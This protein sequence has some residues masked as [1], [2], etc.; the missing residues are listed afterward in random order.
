M[1]ELKI[2]KISTELCKLL[3]SGNR[4]LYRENVYIYI[5]NKMI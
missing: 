4:P 2:D 3:D 5:Y 1:K